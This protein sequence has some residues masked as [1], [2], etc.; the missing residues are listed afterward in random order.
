MSATG[1]VK[2]LR[3]Q[4]E[5]LLARGARDSAD[6]ETGDP[7]ALL[8]ELSVHQIELELQNQELMNARQEAEEARDKYYDLY[9]FAPVAYITLDE[10]A[11]ILEINFTGA[12]L[13]GADRSSLVGRYMQLF[14]DPGD[15]PSF[16]DLIREI[17][18]GV[19]KAS[20][21]IF[22][23]AEG[24]PAVRVRVEGILSH[25][26]EGVK[27]QCRIVMADITAQYKAE[28]ELVRMNEQLIMAQRSAGAGVWDWNIPAD[29]MQW[30]DELYRLFGLDPSITAASSDAMR[31]LIH[32]ND[33]A[34]AMKSFDAAIRDHVQMNTEC[35]IISGDGEVRWINFL[36][37]AVYD[38]QGMPLRMSG[39]CLNIMER[40][41]FEEALL[42]RN[43]ELEHF[44]KV[45]VDREL[46]M[47]ELKKQ[48]NELYVRAGEPPR[49]K[50]DITDD[51]D[52]A[53]G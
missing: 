31:N 12:R 21:S 20:C 14:I 52:D 6:G 8:H 44:N 42:A 5:E 27:P 30:S 26:A 50:I 32:P 24:A 22:L 7:G 13:M 53:T 36:G 48:V 37:N 11:R 2:E 47:V 18:H 43:D 29:T 4:A 28:N 46:R 35:R 33:R 1:N 16:N 9:D 41:R 10:K 40:K 39:I 38:G 15:V 23:A 25:F 49:Y 51:P 19:E 17:L 45:A 34:I 3:R